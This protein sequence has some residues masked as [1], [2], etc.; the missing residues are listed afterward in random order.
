MGVK[1]VCTSDTL[2]PRTSSYDLS[3]SFPPHSTL[4]CRE[5]ANHGPE[6]LRDAGDGAMEDPA[7]INR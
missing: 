6:P 4:T 2:K 5:A 1:G 7:V 3:F